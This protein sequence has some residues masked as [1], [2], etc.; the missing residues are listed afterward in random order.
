MR[1]KTRE[2]QIQGRLNLGRSNRTRSK[3]GWIK[4]NID[5]NEGR[6]KLKLGYIKTAGDQNRGR[7]KATKIRRKEDRNQGRLNLGQNHRRSKSE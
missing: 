1:I 6:T 3:L 2:D 7:S 5:Q 4:I